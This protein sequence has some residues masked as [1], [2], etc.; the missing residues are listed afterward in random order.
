MIPIVPEVTSARGVPI[1]YLHIKNVESFGA[2]LQ[3]LLHGNSEALRQG[4][5]NVTEELVTQNTHTQVSKNRKAARQGVRAHRGQ[6]AFWS[7]LPGRRRNDAQGPG[8]N[9][10]S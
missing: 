9:H 10:W 2:T 3:T 6:S 8:L 5:I 4:E 7:S 1:K